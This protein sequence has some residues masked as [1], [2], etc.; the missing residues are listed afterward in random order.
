MPHIRT[1]R[2]VQVVPLHDIAFETDKRAPDDPGD[3]WSIL[4]FDGP[5]VEIRRERPDFWRDYRRFKWGTK[6]E[7]VLVSPDLTPFLWK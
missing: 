6:G 7:G 2:G 4:T 3:G 5:D 1:V